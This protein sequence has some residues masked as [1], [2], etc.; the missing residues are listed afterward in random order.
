MPTS[1]V[2]GTSKADYIVVS[3]VLGAAYVDGGAGDD[4]IV[5][6]GFGD[7]LLGG[8]GNDQLVGGS[9]ADSLLGGSGNDSLSG[10]D[11][12]DTE[13]PRVCRRPVSLSQAASVISCWLA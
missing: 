6:N 10:N 7:T 9:G 13:P 3:T 8:D 12:N 4:R 5:G 1:V 2:N 11:G